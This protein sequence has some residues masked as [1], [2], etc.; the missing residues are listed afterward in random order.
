MTISFENSNAPC[1]TVAD[2]ML[3]DYLET[4]WELGAMSCSGEDFDGEAQAL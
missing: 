2:Q 1:W 3:S 4:N